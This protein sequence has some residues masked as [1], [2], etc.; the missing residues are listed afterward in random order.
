MEE[1]NAFQVCMFAPDIY[2]YAGTAYQMVQ[3]ASD[4]ATHRVPQ[5]NTTSYQERNFD[6]VLNGHIVIDKTFEMMLQKIAV[7]K[8]A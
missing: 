1:R 5:R 4:F 2:K 7:S 3:A 8:V 6:K